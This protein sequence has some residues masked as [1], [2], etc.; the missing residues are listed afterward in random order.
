MLKLTKAFIILFA[1]SLLGYGQLQA[2]HGHEEKETRATESHSEEN[3]DHA[4]DA[5]AEEGFNAGE[6]VI[7]HV[8]DS[9]DW[10]IT[11]W[12]GTPISIPLPIILYSKQPELHDGKAF[13]VFMS[14]KFHHGHGAY[15]G[16][17]ISESEEYKGKV[18]E[19]D[20]AGHEIGTPIDIS[21]TKTIAGIL[22]SVVILLWLVFATAN[23]AKKNKGK[24][25]TGVQNA[26]EPIIFFIRDEVAKPAIGEHKYEKFM[27]F[28]LTL[29]FF[30]LIN[31]FMGLIP[32]PPFGANVTGNIGVTMVLAL[33]TF[34]VTTING[35]KH[36]WKEIYN[37]DVP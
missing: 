34:A 6:F 21:I 14:S 35:N 10:H 2:Q 30:I 8:S 7:D 9:Y 4:S 20:A 25:P 31:N 27:P 18:V 17:R 5:H 22:A 1:V 11:D 16:F 26:L 3:E 37:P 29:F 23:L 15:K 33:F 19:L 24:A 13:Q 28:L 32:I 36:Y 12:K